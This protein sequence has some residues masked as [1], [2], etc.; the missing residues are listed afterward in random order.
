MFGLKRRKKAALPKEPLSLHSIVHVSN[1]LLDYQ[2]QL[3]VS[4]VRSLDQLQDLQH[5]FQHVLQENEELKAELNSF[6][7]RFGSVEQAASQFHGVK[8]EILDSVEHAQGKVSELKL[9]SQQIQESFEVTQKKFAEFTSYVQKIRDCMKQIV[10]IADQT[11]LLAINASIEAAR[12]GVHGKGFAVVAGEVKTLATNIKDLVSTVDESI[13]DMEH[14]ST[15]LQESFQTSQEALTKNV[16]DVDKT[17]DVFEQITTA[18]GGTEAVQD[19][20]SNAIHEFDGKLQEL[21]GAFSGQE[22]L[23]EEVLEH[24]HKANELGSTKSSI[25][26]QMTNLIIQIPPIAKELEEKGL[27]SHRE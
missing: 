17:F 24:I 4:E 1:S 23:F 18:A 20:I 22:Q 21:T 27:D 14:G 8:Q 6:H 2:K 7:E 9:S 15:E 25:F 3:S 26:E 16:D 11:N 12:A 13:E 19:E 5:A 10:T